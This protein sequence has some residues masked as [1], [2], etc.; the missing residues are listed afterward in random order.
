MK[1]SDQAKKELLRLSQTDEFKFLEK[2]I[3]AENPGTVEA[4][5]QFTDFIQFLHKMADH[6]LREPRPMKGDFKF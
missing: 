1:L 2:K 5:N 3:F 6:P 4:T